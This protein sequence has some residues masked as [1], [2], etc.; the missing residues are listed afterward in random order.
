[1]LTF[2]QFLI[3]VEATL[4]IH[5]MVTQRA[6]ITAGLCDWM[7]STHTVHILLEP[8]TGLDQTAI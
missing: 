4:G 6:D 5:W 8:D 1:M 2:S 3:A 7:I